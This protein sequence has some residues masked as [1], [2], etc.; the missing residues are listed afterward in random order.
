MKN[1][2][3]LIVCLSVVFTTMSCKKDEAAAVIGG[4]TGTTLTTTDLAGS[5]SSTSCRTAGAPAGTS[6]KDG[7]SLQA[8]GNY[9]YYVTVV[10]SPTCA[11]GAEEIIKYTQ[12]GVWSVEGAATSPSGAYKVKFTVGSAAFSA[13]GIATT[14]RDFFNNT[15]NCGTPMLNLVLT[16][17]STVSTSGRVCNSYTAFPTYT[18]S[19]Y[20]VVVFAGSTMQMYS[21]S[22]LWN[23]GT[24]GSYPA[25]VNTTYTY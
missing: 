2:L 18:T 24:A 8:N 11:L 1:R 10:D 9:N 4:A 15:T 20:N 25:T 7:Y 13:P 5:P 16:S 14:Y 12:F 6:Y 21:G 17:S 23:S 19:Y 3:F 22:Q